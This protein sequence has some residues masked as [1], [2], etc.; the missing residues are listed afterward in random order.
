MA[1]KTIFI[2][3]KVGGVLTAAHSITLASSDG[4]YGIKELTSGDIIASD[5]T[6]TD[7]PST[8]RYEYTFNAESNISYLVSWKILTNSNSTA[9]FKTQTIEPT[10]VGAGNISGVPEFKGTF[11]QGGLGNVQIRI[12]KFNGDPVDPELITVTIR[13]KAGT[14][15]E[16]D[17]P[18]KV[19]QGFYVYDWSIDDDQTPGKYFVLWEYTV[20]DITYKELQEVIVAADC[21]D[22]TFYSGPQFILRSGL[23]LFMECAM[24]IP[25][26][27]EEAVPT[28]DRKTFQFTKER[29]NQSPQV[30]IYRNERI[31]NDG[32]EVNHSRGSVK[33]DET[34]LPQDVVS[35][36]YTF[37]WFSDDQMDQFILNG[38]NMLN[39]FPPFSPQF[40]A[41]SIIT[42]SPQHVPVVL[43][44]AAI[45]ALRTLM[46]CLQF[47]QPAQFFGGLEQAQKAFGNFETLKQNFEKTWE[48]LLEQ[49]K[50][51]PYPSTRGVV[52]PEFTLPGG[53]SRWFRYLFS[54]GS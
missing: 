25:V 3:H 8:G 12:S 23:E 45:E 9:L 19:K 30:R 26:Y 34:L 5:G 42:R 51:G 16:A 47:Q 17:C 7:N 52:T 50:F 6:G 24:H 1:F 21:T 41:N 43:H 20:D 4:T 27:A 40:D 37:R 46:M 39:T 15:I 33:F 22:S 35:A 48:K 18:E 11:V 29:W 13:D 32:I 31:M 38:I 14:E 44:G 49:K 28:R 10:T 36:D 2:N 54:G 53:R